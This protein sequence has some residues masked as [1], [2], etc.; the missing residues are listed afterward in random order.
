MVGLGQVAEAASASD[1]NS[2]DAFALLWPRCHGL[3]QSRRDSE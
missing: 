3:Q 1:Y 2:D